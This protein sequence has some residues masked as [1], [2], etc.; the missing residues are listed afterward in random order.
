MTANF[1]LLKYAHVIFFVLAFTAHGKF[2]VRLVHVKKPRLNIYALT[3]F[4][5]DITCPKIKTAVPL[6]FRVQ[7]NASGFGKVGPGPTVLEL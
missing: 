3:E 2:S 5:S 7:G 1:S 4:A 6:I